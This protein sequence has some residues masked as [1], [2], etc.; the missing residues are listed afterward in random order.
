MAVTTDPPLRAV[1]AVDRMLAAC[2]VAGM[3][4]GVALIGALHLI[5]PTSA[6]SPMR[7]TISE[8]QLSELGWL[9]NLAI[10]ILALGSAAFGVV[11]VRRGTIG[12]WSIDTVLITA[13]VLG[14]LT[15]AGFTKH[16]WAVGPST[17]GQIHRIGSMVAFLSLPVAVI[18]LSRRLAHSAARWSFWLGVGSLAWFLPLLGGM[19]LRPLTG[20]PWYRA[21]PLGLVERGLAGFQVA[22]LVVLALVV[23]RPIEVT[24]R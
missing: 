16:N 8:Y 21:V 23:L 7:R 24:K 12:R 20:V 17:E 11:L 18:L 10:V 22:A 3:T 6:I 4:I 13:W 15:V 1:A 14:L 19:L 9:F 5:E 2:A